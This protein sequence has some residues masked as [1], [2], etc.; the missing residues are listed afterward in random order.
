MRGVEIGVKVL[1]FFFGGVLPWVRGLV[2]EHLDEFVETGCEERAEDG[3]DPVDPVVGVELVGYD[4]GAE[5]T[6]GVY[7]TACEVDACLRLY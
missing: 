4:G 3:P 7:G 2:L 1:A 6:G 5:G